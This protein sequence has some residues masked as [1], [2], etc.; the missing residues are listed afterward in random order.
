VRGTSRNVCSVVK[1]SI[2]NDYTSGSVVSPS[3][4]GLTRPQ[5]ADGGK[6]SNMEGSCEC[7]E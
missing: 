5:V 1:F 6:A 2:E 4:H 7:I 3:R